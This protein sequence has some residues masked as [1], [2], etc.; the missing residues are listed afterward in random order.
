MVSWGSGHGRGAGSEPAAGAGCGMVGSPCRPLQGAAH[1]DSGGSREGR[2]GGKSSGASG[3]PGVN[4][5][6]CWGGASSRLCGRQQVAVKGGAPRGSGSAG[7]HSPRISSTF[8][9]RAR[10]ARQSPRASSSAQRSSPGESMASARAP[11]RR[12]HVR[13]RPR[14]ARVTCAPGPAPVRPSL[15][16]PLRFL[17]TPLRRPR[18]PVNLRRAAGPGR[19]GRVA[20]DGPESPGAADMGAARGPTMRAPPTG[21]LLSL[22]TASPPRS[23]PPLALLGPVGRGPSPSVESP[24]LDA[25]VSDK[26]FGGGGRVLSRVAPPGWGGG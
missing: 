2:R 13:A 5:D 15:A 4:T 1:E 7:A 22:P 25:T 19:G 3:N 20:G 26:G 8:R 9:E 16:L 10:W 14:P 6:R 18:S 12:R 24:P 17:R 21:D 23:L 11:P